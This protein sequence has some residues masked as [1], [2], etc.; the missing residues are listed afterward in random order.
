[1][2]VFDIDGNLLIKSIFRV[3]ALNVGNFSN[4]ESGAPAGTDSM[5]NMFIETFRK[6]SA[7][8][9]M[10][11]EWDKYYAGNTTSDSIFGFLKPYR[12]AYILEGQGGYPGQ[13]IYSD[14]K[15]MSEYHET[16][17]QDAPY[18]FIDNAVEVDGKEIHLICTHFTWKTQEKRQSQIRQIMDYITN[19]NIAHYI[20]A[21]DMNLGLHGQDDR[22]QDTETKFLVARQDV[23]LLESNGAISA[24][25]GKWGLR[26]KD[27]FLN[28]AGHGGWDAANTNMFDNIVISPTLRF[29][30]IS[31]ITTTATDHDAIVSDITWA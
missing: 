24:Q 13:A 16:F 26:D 5:Y 10:F 4:G 22:E 27:G 8:I 30:N 25:G 7:N 1:M 20:I 18:Y 15:I 14:Y 23:D 6:C 12:S 29:N 28:T 31:V 11:S 17:N 3:C 9:Y 2:G 19:N 21:G